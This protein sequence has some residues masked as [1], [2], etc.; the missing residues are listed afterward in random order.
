VYGS[1]IIIG[2]QQDSCQFA[3]Y[4]APENRLIIF[5]DDTQ[6][7]WTTASTMLDYETVAGGDKFGNA[8]VLRLPEGV[9][10]T[11]D[12]DP[13]GVSLIHD[14]PRYNGASHKVEVHAHFN[15]SIVII[16]Y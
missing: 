3:V 16:I 8:Y 11:V 6:Q 15:V 14:K 1:R 7:R 12:A 9:S 2:D 13:T 4:K 10:D 5:A